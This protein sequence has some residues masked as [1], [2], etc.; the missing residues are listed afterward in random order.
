[1]EVAK[2]SSK[3]QLTLPKK[4]REDLK[5]EAGDRILLVKEKGGWVLVRLP[6]NP[7]EALRYLGRKAGLKG[8]SAEV[9]KEM[10]EWEG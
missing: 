5:A 2:L 1:M 8:D 3:F 4:V 7:V 10:E 6:R 9:H